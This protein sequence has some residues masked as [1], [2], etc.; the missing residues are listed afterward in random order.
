MAVASTI[1]LS[2]LTFKT[3]APQAGFA[4]GRVRTCGCGHKPAAPDVRP[5]LQPNPESPRLWRVWLRATLLCMIAFSHCLPVCTTH[6]GVQ[7]DY[8]S[9]VEPERCTKALASGSKIS[10]SFCNRSQQTS[11]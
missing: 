3:L 2:L 9:A 4:P 1:I 7:A 5:S 8:D 10:S 11:A 6:T